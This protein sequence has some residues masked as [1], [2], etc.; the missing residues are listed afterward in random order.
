M[1]VIWFLSSIFEL[2]SHYLLSIE[3]LALSMWLVIFPVDAQYLSVC[4]LVL[5]FTLKTTC[6]EGPFVCAFALRSKLSF[7]L[8]KT[9]F[10][11]TL[12]DVPILIDELSLS[13]DLVFL[14]SLVVLHLS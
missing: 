11:A 9:V 12:K 2:D 8:Q 3:Q 14:V 6:L 13:C 4:I 10:E 1:S 5:S 7:A